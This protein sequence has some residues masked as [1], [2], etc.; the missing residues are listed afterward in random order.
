MIK[1]EKHKVH[2][3]FKITLNNND[4]KIILGSIWVFSQVWTSFRNFLESTFYFLFLT[5]LIH[6][7][8]FK[9]EGIQKCRDVEAEQKIFLSS[10]SNDYRTSRNR[11]WE[12]S[13]SKNGTRNRK[14]MSYKKYVS[15]GTFIT[16]FISSCHHHKKKDGVPLKISWKKNSNVFIIKLFVF[17]QLQGCCFVGRKFLSTFSVVFFFSKSQ[18]E[19]ICFLLSLI[20]PCYSSRWSKRNSQLVRLW[21]FFV[22]IL[23]ISYWYAK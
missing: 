10:Q 6:K 5:Y 19:I 3:L 22:A 17:T 11:F 18:N 16:L 21:V 20:K 8:N 15:T 1:I 9:S 14:K 2:M 12:M 4:G 7:T 13:F 23:C